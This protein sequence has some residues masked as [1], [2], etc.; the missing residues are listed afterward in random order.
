MK[1]ILFRYHTG[2][3]A[4]CNCKALIVTDKKVKTGIS[5]RNAILL[6]EKNYFCLFKFEMREML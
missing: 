4:F 1:I 3:P 5:R 6:R 2:K